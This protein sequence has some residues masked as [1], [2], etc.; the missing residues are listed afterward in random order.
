MA[1]ETLPY[2]SAWSTETN[3]TAWDP[4]QDWTMFDYLGGNDGWQ[5]REDGVVVNDDKRMDNDDWLV[6]PAINCHGEEDKEV[7]FRVAWDRALTSNFTLY[8]ST[9]YAGDP[10]AAN[11]TLVAANIIESDQP[12]GLS[13]ASY[14][15]KKFAFTINHAAVHFA[16]QYAPITPGTYEGSSNRARVKDF[17]VQKVVSTDIE[18]DETASLTISPNPVKDVVCVECDTKSGAEVT[19]NIYDVLGQKVL[20]EKVL[21]NGDKIGVQVGELAKG[22]YLLVVDDGQLIGQSRFLKN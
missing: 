13:T 11:W 14:V 22:I 2:T 18:M 21:N 8:Y 9:D 20:S 7:I 6:S 19:I 5:W 4:V 17:V 12:M 1:Q 3:G 15:E 16:F 10:K